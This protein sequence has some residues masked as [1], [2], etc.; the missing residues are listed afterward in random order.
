MSKAAVKKC[1]ITIVTV[2]L[3]ISI[4]I[5]TYL[6][7]LARHNNKFYNFYVSKDIESYEEY[8]ALV[9]YLSENGTFGYYSYGFDC[10]G[11]DFEFVY[12]LTAWGG[13]RIYEN[14]VDFVSPRKCTA[15]LHGY[16]IL[17]NYECQCTD[18]NDCAV[19]RIAS[20][21]ND[22]HIEDGKC[23]ILYESPYGKKSG[24][25]A[26]TDRSLFTVEPYEA[27]ESN[28]YT[29]IKYCVKYDGIML[30]TFFSCVPVDEA[31]RS[32]FVDNLII[33]TPG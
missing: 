20:S 32:I 29:N 18:K 6:L 4:S 31:I 16:I 14:L 23:I 5:V 22:F 21:Q 30:F 3:C 15:Y 2:I 11:N 24:Y 33:Y 19:K 12:R 13:K 8:S 1:V 9:A 7:I 28:P 26:I 17:N 10:T 27:D 25:P